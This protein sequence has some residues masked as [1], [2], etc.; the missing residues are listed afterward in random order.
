MW[1]RES[2]G[3]HK[4][5]VS[6]FACKGTLAITVLMSE[7]SHAGGIGTIFGKWTLAVEASA[8]D[9]RVRRATTELTDWGKRPF[10]MGAPVEGGYNHSG[11]VLPRTWSVDLEC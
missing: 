5:S 4:H 1:R 11:G 2:A 7:E 10:A 6:S 9:G 3:P 8:S